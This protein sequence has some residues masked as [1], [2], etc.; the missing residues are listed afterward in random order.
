MASIPT[1][2]PLAEVQVLRKSSAGVQHGPGGGQQ[3]EQQ[4]QQPPRP[5]E[6]V[7]LDGRGAGFRAQAF[8]LY[9]KNAVFQRRNWCSNVCLLSAPI[10]FCLM[11]FGIQIAINKL[12]LT[13]DD[14]AVR[15]GRG[16]RPGR[17]PI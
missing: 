4:Q 10:F 7:P 17:A 1:A 5:G 2:S 13:G 16:L 14:Y 11:L 15:R 9:R 3:H 12:L 8:A 6:A